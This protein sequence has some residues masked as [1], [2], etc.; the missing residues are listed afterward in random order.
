MRYYA[1][2]SLWCNLTIY[3]QTKR[4]YFT[5]LKKQIEKPEYGKGKPYNDYELGFY[6]TENSKRCKTLFV[7]ALHY[8]YNTIRYNN[9]ISCRIMIIIMTF[10]LCIS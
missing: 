6:C 1:V 7:R 4:L 2:I 10:Y 3:N 5:V 8:R 9:R